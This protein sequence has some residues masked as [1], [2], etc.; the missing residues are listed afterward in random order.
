MSPVSGS[1]GGIPDTNTICPARVQADTGAPHFSKLLSNGSTRMISRSMALF[2]SPLASVP[3]Q[4]NPIRDPGAD[5]ED[6][7]GGDGRHRAASSAA[8]HG[9]DGD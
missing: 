5:A 1:N 8:L 9:R 4:D 3:E 6:V 2:Q 7:K